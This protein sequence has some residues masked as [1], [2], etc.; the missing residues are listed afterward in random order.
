MAWG[1]RHLDDARVRRNFESTAMAIFEVHGR[2]LGESFLQTSM[3]I[4]TF[5][6]AFMKSATNVLQD[7]GKVH[8]GQDTWVRSMLLSFSPSTACCFALDV[9]SRLT[10]AFPCL[11]ASA[12]VNGFLDSILQK[13]RDTK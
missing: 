9:W 4:K 5:L 10:D 6:E 7:W 1:E 12:L 2:K 8:A 11:I 13:D 3:V